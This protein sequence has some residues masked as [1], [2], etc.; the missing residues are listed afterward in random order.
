MSTPIKSLQYVQFLREIKGRVRDAQHKAVLSVNRELIQL[1]WDIG[2]SLVEKVER[3]G[4][5]E[6]VVERLALD[7]QKEFISI[8]GFSKEN[9]WTMKR[10]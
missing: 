10:L 4:W 1:Y 5:G 2:K 3:L 8:K 6:G 7:L 9:L